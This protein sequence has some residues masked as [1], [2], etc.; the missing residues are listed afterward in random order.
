MV[1][2][3]PAIVFAADDSK[4]EKVVQTCEDAAKSKEKPKSR[5][6]YRSRSGGSP[7]SNY[8]RVVR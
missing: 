7:M 4:Q 8:R 2:L 6:V 5:I 3:A 1:S